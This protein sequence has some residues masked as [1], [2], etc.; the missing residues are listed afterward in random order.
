MKQLGFTLL[1]IT[2]TL[3]ILLLAIHLTYSIQKIFDRSL[4][5]LEVERLT[6]MIYATQQRSFIEN[7]SQ[8]IWFTT[9]PS[10]YKRDHEPF[11]CLTNGVYFGTPSSVRGPPSRPQHLPQ[12]PITFPNN[13]LTLYCDGTAQAGT[14]YLTDNRKTCCYALTVG[15]A[16]D[17]FLRSYRYTNKGWQIIC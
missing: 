7:T 17:V 1:E 13:A 11:N 12:N 3:S 10:G 4:V 5:A 6:A 9:Q 16:P 8:K 2:V 14:L 15:V